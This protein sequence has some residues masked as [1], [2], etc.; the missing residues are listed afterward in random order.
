MELHTYNV[1]E[2]QARHGV[3]DDNRMLEVA[4]LVGVTDSGPWM[5]GGSVRR[6]LSGKTQ[7]SDF[8]VGVSSNEQIELLKESLKLKGFVVTKE[9]KHYIELVGSVGE[10]SEKIQIL[11]HVVGDIQSILDSFDFTI[12]QCAFDGTN[13]MVGPY[14]MWDLGRKRLAIHKITFGASTIRR[15]LKYAA[16]GYTM[17]SGCANDILRSAIEK[18]SIVDNNTLYID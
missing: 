16:Q 15:L 10:K 12:C 11:R 2:F 9:D 13:I 8:D 1:T 4:K 17:C 7:D 14:T 18:P 3:S 5:V 6:F